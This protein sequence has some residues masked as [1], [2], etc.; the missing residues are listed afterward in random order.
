M[1]NYANVL[2]SNVSNMTSAERT[3]IYPGINRWISCRADPSE[4]T[5][6]KENMSIL[7]DDNINYLVKVKVKNWKTADLTTNRT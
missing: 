4:I 2:V 5:L 1:T 3:K 6:K 7:V